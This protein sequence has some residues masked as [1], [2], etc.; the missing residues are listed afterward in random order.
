MANTPFTGLEDTALLIK[1]KLDGT[2]MSDA[3]G[4]QSIYVII[5]ST[6]YQLPNWF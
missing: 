6:E 3:Y 1:I 5:P 4:I 2:D